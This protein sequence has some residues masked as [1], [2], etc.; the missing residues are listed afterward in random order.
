MVRGKGVPW[1]PH[2]GQRGRR[3]GNDRGVGLVLVA[4]GAGGRCG[5]CWGEA[6]TANSYRKSEMAS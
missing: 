2:D 4:V 6:K 5:G 3:G 1:V